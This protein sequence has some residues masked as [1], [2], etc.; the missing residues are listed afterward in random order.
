[1][2]PVLAVEAPPDP[3]K[4]CRAR[5]EPGSR[6]TKRSLCATPD[7][8]NGF[9]QRCADDVR[10]ALPGRY[11]SFEHSTWASCLRYSMAAPR[12]A[13]GVHYELALP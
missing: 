7:A 8:I 5:N 13:P 9:L 1:M 10:A 6:R 2:P 11:S 12:K 3:Q 4:P